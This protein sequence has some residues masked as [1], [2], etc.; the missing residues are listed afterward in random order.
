MGGI[1]WI[2]L[3]QHRNRWWV[4]VNVAM[5]LQAQ[6]NAGD[7]SSSRGCVSFSGRTLL[8]GVN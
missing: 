8:H 5:N 1:D 2:D 7:F 6:H 3:A 4:L